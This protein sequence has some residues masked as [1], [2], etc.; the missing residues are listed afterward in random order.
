MAD[1]I[2][3]WPIRGTEAQV[4]A[5]P[6]Y[7]G[8][9]YFTTDTNKIYLDVN[10]SHH[11]MGG[12]GGSGSGIIYAY[13]T[14]EQIEKVSENEDD[15]NYKILMDALEVSSVEPQKD[16]LILNSDGRFF[17]VLSVDSENR[18]IN[19]LLLAV[20]GSGGGG[21]G[22]QTVAD[23]TLTYDAETINNNFTFIEG[24]S[25]YASFIATSET[26]SIVYLQ[27]SIYESWAAYNNGKGSPIKSFTRQAESGE[28]YMLNMSEFAAGSEMV[29]RVVATAPSSRTPE[30]VVKV[31]TGINIVAMSIQKFQN[32][33]FIGVTTPNTVGGLVLEYVPYGTGLTCTLHASVDNAEIDVGKTLLPTNMGSRQSV[34]IPMQT[35][36]MHTVAL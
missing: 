2:K 14:E 31:L 25:Q 21:G 8:K 23:I 28:P 24:K 11:L 32:N 3:F 36:G 30:G 15:F 20:S 26:D 18:V 9:L 16:A 34:A 5:Q 13:G 12:A 6:V 22:G 10:G 1:K 29:L 33:A 4:L 17:R 7:D 19:A 27:F 35:H